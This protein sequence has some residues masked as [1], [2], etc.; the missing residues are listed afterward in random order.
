[1]KASEPTARTEFVW[2]NGVKPGPRKNPGISEMWGCGVLTQW[3][4]LQG[5]FYY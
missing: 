1:M 4:R 5:P 2:D 3:G